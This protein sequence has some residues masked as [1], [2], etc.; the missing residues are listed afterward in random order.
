MGGTEQQ[1]TQEAFDSNF[2]KIL[3]VFY[4]C[5]LNYLEILN[6]TFKYTQ[7]FL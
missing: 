7:F 4:I 2:F 6:H 1:Y 5:T 3:K